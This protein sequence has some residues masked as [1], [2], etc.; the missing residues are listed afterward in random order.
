MSRPVDLTKIREAD[1]ALRRARALNPHVRM[2]TMDELTRITQ[3]RPGRP[4][5]NDE[6]TG[7]MTIRLP[8]SLLAR[9]DRHVAQVETRLGRKASR[10]A[11]ARQALQRYLD[12]QEA[13]RRPGDTD[14]S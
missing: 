3:R 9:L 10:T 7:T 11:I 13:A 8:Q 12:A 6:P 1:A 2:P 14:E 4:T 5:R